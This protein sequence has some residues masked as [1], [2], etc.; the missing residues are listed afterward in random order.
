VLYCTQTWWVSFKCKS[1][2]KVS[3]LSAIA[4]FL[5]L[6]M[7]DQTTALADHEV[8][9]L[10]VMGISLVFDIANI[11]QHPQTPANAA[12]GSTSEEICV[13]LF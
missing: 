13:V 1:T 12:T 7:P 5:Q 11:R 3:L 6:R 10:L 2:H 9:Q 4:A 8:H